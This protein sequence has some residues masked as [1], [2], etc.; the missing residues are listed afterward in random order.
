MDKLDT[1]TDKIHLLG[2]LK[3]VLKTIIY[4]QSE[5]VKLQNQIDK[6]KKDKK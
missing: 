4:L 5:Q 2:Q 3:V 1:A 6:L